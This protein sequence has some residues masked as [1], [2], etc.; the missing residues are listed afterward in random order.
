M[1]TD[2]SNTINTLAVAKA[3]KKQADFRHCKNIGSKLNYLKQKMKKQA[4]F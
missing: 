1:K 4:D 2:F 3:K